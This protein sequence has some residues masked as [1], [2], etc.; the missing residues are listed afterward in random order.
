MRVLD[1]QAYRNMDVT[2]ECISRILE[3]R[4]R[5][6]LLSFQTGFNLVS[7]VG[8]WAILESISGL[9]SSSVITEPRY[10]KLVTVSS[11][12][13]STLMSLL[14]PL[15]LFVISLVQNSRF[16]SCSL[17][18]DYCNA[19]LAGSPQVLLDKI[20]KVINCSAR[21]IYKA[22][23]SA[24]I[25]PLLFDFHWLPISIRIQYKIVL[26]CFHII[27][28]TAPHYLFELLHLY[29]SRSLR[30][31]SDTRI[32]RVPRVCWRTLGEISFHF[33]GPVIRNSL[34]FSVRHAT[35]LPSFKSNLKTHLFP[36]AY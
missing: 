6:M 1:S 21:L 19:F 24:P 28:G 30:S 26:T 10:L 15:V 27:S 36:S 4:V 12:C 9:E 17:Y 31:A 20:Q 2:R 16:L 8:V 5:E 23:K 29:S 32:F 14:M 22:Q 11:F 35:S 25:T 18:A 13:P 7:A 33:I 3:L 34:S